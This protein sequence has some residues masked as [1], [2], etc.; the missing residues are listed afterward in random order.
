MDL[1]TFNKLS[2]SVLLCLLV[3]AVANT[4]VDISYPTGGPAQYRVVEVESEPETEVAEAA[5]EEEAEP[6]AERTLAELLAVADAS[7]GER[8]ARECA[9]CH[10]FQDGGPNRVGPHLYGV[11]GRE[12][13]SI[14]G[15]GYSSALRD[16]AGE[17]SYERMDCFLEN[18]RQCVPGTSMAY[19]GIRDAERRANMIAYLASLG[20]APPLP[21]VESEAQDSPAD[22]D[23]AEDRAQAET[24]GESRP[25]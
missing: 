19:G 7:A 14:E 3:I 24:G 18:P 4:A 8:V 6:E 13:A 20:D 15:F 22:A 12:V 9:A 2:A 11:I 5:P 10:V 25:Q 16:F 17:W 21:E 1:W 23:G